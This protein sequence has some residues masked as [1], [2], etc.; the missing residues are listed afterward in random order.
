MNI[1]EFL[2][3]VQDA[4]EAFGQRPPPARTVER[5]WDRDEQVLAGCPPGRVND[6]LAVLTR[7]ETRSRITPRDIVN[8]IR[9]VRRH[10]P[11]AA[12]RGTIV[13]ADGNPDLAATAEWHLLRSAKA[14]AARTSQPW[15]DVL[16]RLRA[17]DTDGQPTDGRKDL[18]LITPPGDGGRERA[19]P[20]KNQEPADATP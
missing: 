4:Y 3:L 6:A 7:D 14:E 15:L 13:D 19:S 12:G 11:S 17:A 20:D 16:D 10:A 8:A 9:T 2:L 5:L 1:A 18:Q